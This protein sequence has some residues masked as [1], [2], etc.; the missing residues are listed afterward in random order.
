MEAI[1]YHKYGSP[2]DVL[3]LQGIREPKAKE[4]EV[5]T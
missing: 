2:G 3:E 4:K 5:L 1:G